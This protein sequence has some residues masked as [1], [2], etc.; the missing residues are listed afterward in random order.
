MPPSPSLPPSPP[1]ADSP[2]PNGF[3]FKRIAVPVYGP[4][5]LFGLGEGAIL[6]IIPLVAREL[7]TVRRESLWLEV[8]IQSD[9]LFASGSADLGPAARDTS[10]S[11]AWPDW[12]RPGLQARGRWC[13]RSPPP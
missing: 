10:A 3:S 11:C 12:D 8:E 2:P 1:T 6:P 13:W 9:L 5:L 4:S 7:V